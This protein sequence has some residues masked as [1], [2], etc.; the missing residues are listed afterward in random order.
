MPSPLLTR[1][2]RIGDGLN[3]QR[4]QTIRKI[5][6]GQFAEVY[7]VADTFNDG[8]RVALKIDRTLEVKTVRQEQKVLKRLQA[9]P[10]VVRLLEQGTH[11]NR[12]FVVMELLGMNVADARKVNADKGRWDTSTAAAIGRHLLDALSGMHGLGY[13]HRDVKPANFAITPR[14]A[15]VHQGVWHVI[16]FGLARRYVDDAGMVLP[17]RPDAAFRGSTTY[18]SLAAH[19][20]EDLGRRDDLWSWLYVVVEMVS[21][22]LPWRSE[23]GV[24]RDAARDKELAVR[25]KR[26]CMEAPEQ[27]AANGHLPPALLRISNHLAGLAFEAAP[28]YGLLRDCL[29]EMASNGTF[30]MDAATEAAL[31]AE[32]DTPLSPIADAMDTPLSPQLDSPASPLQR[33]SFPLPAPQSRPGITAALESP[34]LTP[35]QAPTGRHVTLNGGMDVLPSSLPFPSLPS[36][37][38]SSA[39]RPRSISPALP[40]IKPPSSTRAEATVPYHRSRSRSRGRS[41]SR[42]RSRIGGAS[43]YRSPERDLVSNRGSSAAY[44]ATRFGRSNRRDSRDK[45]HDRDKGRERERDRDWEA[46]ADKDQDGQYGGNSG[47]RRSGRSRSSAS[48]QHQTARHRASERDSTRVCQNSGRD[49]DSNGALPADDLGTNVSRCRHVHK[50]SLRIKQGKASPEALTIKQALDKIQLTEGLGLAAYLIDVLVGA[51]IPE[52]AQQMAELLNELQDYTQLQRQ[53]A[54]FKAQP[55]SSKR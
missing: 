19:E 10:T 28:D 27:L 22:T 37:P 6:E 32:L 5:G 33:A 3:L 44:V 9:C 46:D 7:E 2:E 35:G 21:G 31:S 4:W 18:A 11:E 53:R 36:Q 12:G 23:G 24:P 55:C 43:R 30:Q 15:A 50:Y 20:G 52:D 13:I 41:R 17:P 14:T 38:Q 16:D 8:R 47:G 48:P 29:Q 34:A 39:P 40:V 54:K 51:V 42:S 49:V 26:E 45:D 1:G 25:L